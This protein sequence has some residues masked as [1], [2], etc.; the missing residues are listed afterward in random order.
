MAEWRWAQC[1]WNLL[2]GGSNRATP[3]WVENVRQHLAR[4]GE[5]Y[6]DRAR[7]EIIYL[8]RKGEDMS[9]LEAVLSVEETLIQHEGAARHRWVGVVFEYATWLRPAEGLGYVEIQAGGCLAAPVGQH[10]DG[11]SPPHNGPQ[12]CASVHEPGKLQLGC[13]KPGET[14]DGV[15]FA[16]FGQPTGSCTYGY[17]KGECHDANST[18]VVS[19]LCLGKNNCSVT[20]ASATFG[21]DPCD[22]TGKELAVQVHCTGDPPVPPPCPSH[23]SKARCSGPRCEWNATAG[24]CI[25]TPP[26]APRPDRYT[27]VT[28]GNVAVSNSSDILFANSTFR[29]LGAFASS[30]LGGSQ[31]ITWQGN[32][33]TDVS[34]GALVLGDL[35]H[36]GETDTAK[37]DSHFKVVDN[38][39]VNLPVEFTGA[40]AIFGGY[41]DSCLIEHNH[42]ANTSYPG[43]YRSPSTCNVFL[44]R[45]L[46][47]LRQV[48]AWA[49]AGGQP[50]AGEATT[51]S[52]R[53][54]LKTRRGSGAATAA[55]C[56]PSDLSPRARSSATC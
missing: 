23:K 7:G 17:S 37:W 41:V 34:S 33:F 40:T 22:G 47:R 20:A 30:A 27:I 39:I 21:S 29:H 31:R 42:I 2:A 19:A 3:T 55:K 10:P 8:P 25:K 32:H 53:T 28:P 54:G 6:Y 18:K 43:A 14:I 13:E 52:W 11:W 49:G 24:Q 46:L 38:T 51:T 5:W 16:S 45:D 26:P 4:P 48:S 50:G 35:A 1:A 36:C 56:T 44:S 15:V 12:Q 9:Q